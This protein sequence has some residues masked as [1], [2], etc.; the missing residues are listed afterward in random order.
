[1]RIVDGSVF[2]TMP[3]GTKFRDINLNTKKPTGGIKVKTGLI[4]DVCDINVIGYYFKFATSGEE[5]SAR[6]NC[7]STCEFLIS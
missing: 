2:L 1:M 6:M 7:P 3:S 4:K 5:C